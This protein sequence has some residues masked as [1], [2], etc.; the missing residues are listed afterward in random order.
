MYVWRTEQFTH[1]YSAFW[2]YFV[3][4]ICTCSLHL[5]S[6]QVDMLIWPHDEV[7]SNTTVEYYEEPHYQY[8]ATE[9]EQNGFHHLQRKDIHT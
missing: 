2:K 8:D 5:L 3:Q 7:N 6:V 9:L 1:K 4:A